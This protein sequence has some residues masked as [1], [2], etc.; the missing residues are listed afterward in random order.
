MGEQ[1]PS[2]REAIPEAAFIE[3]I[4]AYMIKEGSAAAA[5]EKLQ[6]F[7]SACKMIE[8]RLT[9]RKAK[10]KVKIPEIE[11]THVSL[12]QMEAQAKA[13]DALVTHYEL[14][15]SVFAKAKVDALCERGAFIFS[16]PPPPF[17]CQK[18]RWR[19]V[20]RRHVISLPH[21]PPCFFTMSLSGSLSLALSLAL[22]HP[23][24]ILS[25]LSLAPPPSPPPLQ[26]ERA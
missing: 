25:S 2:T 9:Q 6:R 23:A 12:L 24:T 11:A 5:L 16:L 22:P 17:C 15:Q 7:Y 10:L 14:A 26:G 8:Q 1:P 21:R 3:D 19:F 13:G 18:P 4:D 20:W